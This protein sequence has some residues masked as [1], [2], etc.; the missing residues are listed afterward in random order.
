MKTERIFLRVSIE[1]KNSIAN[2]AKRHNTTITEYILSSAENKKIKV[3]SLPDE[4]TLEIKRELSVIGKNLWS[5]IKYNKTLKLTEKI[6]LE[7]IILELKNSLQT[8][9]NYYDCQ[10]NHRNKR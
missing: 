7:R 2:K 10:N 1:T 3:Q 6:N 5:L 9:N 4:Y 8:I